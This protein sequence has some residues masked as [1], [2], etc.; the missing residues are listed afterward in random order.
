MILDKLLEFDPANTAITVT[1][2]STNSF[3]AHGS[4]LIPAASATV[5]PGRDMGSGS[6]DGP[7]PR[8]LV[9]VQQTFTAGGA[10]TLNIQFQGAPDNGSGVAG[11]F[12]TYAESGVIALASLVLGNTIFN[13]DWPRILPMPNT[14]ALLPRFFRLNYVVATGPFTAGQVQSEMVLTQDNYTPYLP[15]VVVNN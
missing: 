12:A 11:A 13:I 7:T 4:G 8:I 10:G 1:A 5:K 15:G 6:D 3:D 14:P 9:L 2:V